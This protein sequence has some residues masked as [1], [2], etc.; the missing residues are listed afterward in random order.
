[1]TATTAPTN[2]VSNAFY[3]QYNLILLGGAGLFSLASA[4][5]VPLAVGLALEL[6]WLGLG[7]RLGAF[8]HHV[9]LQVE[10][11]R[12]S[13]LDDSMLGGMRA[14]GTEHTSRLVAL[15]QAIAAIS[16]RA[17][18]AD[19]PI[20]IAALAELDPLR[21]LFLR[22]CQLH[23][24]LTRRLH[25]L[26][27]MPPEQEV[28]RLSQAYAAEKDLGAR[29]TL[30]QAVKLAQ[31]KVEQQ[32]RMLE[33]RRELERTLGL[34]ERVPSQLHHQQQLGVSSAELAADMHT[35]LSSIAVPE[36]LEVELSE[37]GVLSVLPPSVA[38]ARLYQE[39]T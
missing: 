39:S 21:P 33:M 24:R 27:A 16:S 22:H 29:F 1:M 26:A 25:E 8:R 31:K 18:S 37:L 36:A 2:Y 35:L 10:S 12:R 14:L 4:S 13:R 3:W 28:A 5:L 30:H 38:P 6:V 19:G 23:E 15:E 7:S 32:G 9:D 20:P 34:I 17:S 11:E